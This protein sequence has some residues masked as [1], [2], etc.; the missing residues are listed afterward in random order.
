M[1]YCKVCFCMGC[2][3]F[4]VCYHFVLSYYIFSHYKCCD[5]LGE[6]I[7]VWYS[8]ELLFYPAC[9]LLIFILPSVGI[10]WF[11][12]LVESEPICVHKVL[13]KFICVHSCSD[14]VLL[15]FSCVHWCWLVFTY[16]YWRFVCGQLCSTCVL[17]CLF[18]CV[19]LVSCLCPLPLAGFHPYS[20][21]AHWCSF[22]FTLVL[23]MFTSVLNCLI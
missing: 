18:T 22:V 1:L 9:N 14:C 16:V 17:L 6:Y 19:L 13:F 11:I 2:L 4:H 21:C 10:N 20:A 15:S 5:N 8:Q 23:F 7:K 12:N 3:L